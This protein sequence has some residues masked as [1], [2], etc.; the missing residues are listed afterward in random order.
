MGSLP[1]LRPTIRLKIPSASTATRLPLPLHLSLPLQA[2]L[3]VLLARLASKSVR[4][5]QELLEVPLIMSIR[6]R[7]RGLTVR[8]SVKNH[9]HKSRL[10]RQ[11]QVSFHSFLSPS[12]L[13]RLSCA[14]VIPVF[15]GCFIRACYVTDI[16]QCLICVYPTIEILEYATYYYPYSLVYVTTCIAN[17][18]RPVHSI[19]IASLCTPSPLRNIMSCYHLLEKHR[20]VSTKSRRAVKALILSIKRSNKSSRCIY[21]WPSFLPSSSNKKERDSWKNCRLHSYSPT[22]IKLM[23]YY[24]LVLLL[25]T[26]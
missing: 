1:W 5:T 2:S 10:H 21:Q 9:L 12:F 16:Y 18:R 25:L 19:I 14:R 8:D 22:K 26:A 11:L 15:W 23:I 7:K 4:V 20:Y 17:K 3:P 24:S 13:E 6:R